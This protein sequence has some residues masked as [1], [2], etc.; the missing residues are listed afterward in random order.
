VDQPADQ[1][2]RLAA[3]AIPP[4]TIRPARRRRPSGE[5][6]P[7]PRHLQTSGVGWLIAAVVLVASAMAV[8]SRGLRGVAVEVTIADQAVVQWLADLHAPGLVGAFRGVAALSSWWVLEVVGPALLLTLLLL[9]RFRHLV[10]WLIVAILLEFLSGDVL[11]E[12]LQRPRPFGVVFRAGWGGWA[13]PSLQITLFTAG[14]VA[15]LYSLV[16]EGRWRA[17]GKWA[18]TAVVALV[19]LSRVALGVDAPSDVLV[20]W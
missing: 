9:R 7:L 16:P 3:P 13:L 19:G 18:A 4:E 14:L 17:I 2:T 5:P 8:F 10:I 12:I 15:I 1:S 20:G 11:P 6:P